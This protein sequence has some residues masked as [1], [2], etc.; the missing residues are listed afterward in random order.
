MKILKEEKFFLVQPP[1]HW[2][3]FTTFSTRAFFVDRSLFQK[4]FPIKL[5][6][7]NV[8]NLANKILNNK[9]T[10]SYLSLEGILQKQFESEI[11]FQKLSLG[12]MLHVCTRDEFLNQDIYRHLDAFCKGKIPNSQANTS[13]NYISELWI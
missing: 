11:Y 13:I 4:S 2:N 10:N 5:Y 1:S 12:N 7:H 8:F 3:S 6:K 9:Y